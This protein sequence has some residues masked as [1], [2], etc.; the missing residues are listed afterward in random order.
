[1]PLP[2]PG[3]GARLA[4]VCR[5]P[6]RGVPGP[7]CQ[8]SPGEDRH[9]PRQ[10]DRPGGEIDQSVICVR[11]LVQRS[12]GYQLAQT[13]VLDGILAGRDEPSGVEDAV[14]A[15]RIVDVDLKLSDRS[16][17]GGRQTKRIVSLGQEFEGADDRFLPVSVATRRQ[18]GIQERTER[19]GCVEP[20]K[21]RPEPL[22]VGPVAALLEKAQ[23][24]HQADQRG[25]HQR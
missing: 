9:N 4:R 13:F 12:E 11:E 24:H 15:D 16:G 6:V 2:A 5:H 25:G 17:D 8:V 19:R 3:P 1:M 22:R 20:G 18:S 14:W 23:L 21:C 10:V 7:R